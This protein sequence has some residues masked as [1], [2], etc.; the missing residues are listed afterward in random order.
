MVNFNKS[1]KVL[2]SDPSL[3]ISID[4]PVLGSIVVNRVRFYPGASLEISIDL[5]VLRSIL[6]NRVKF[7]PATRLWK[8]P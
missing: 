7:Y 8:F 4:L 2:S 3:E 5:P 1:S 6:I